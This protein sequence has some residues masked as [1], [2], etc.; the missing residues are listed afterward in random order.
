V[1]FSLFVMLVCLIVD[2]PFVKGDREDEDEYNSE[3][4]EDFN[5]D[6]SGEEGESLGSVDTDVEE[7]KVEDLHADF[8]DMPTSRAKK[9][10]TPNKKAAPKTASVDNLSTQMSSMKVTKVEYVSFTWRFPM[11]MYSVNEGTTKKIFIEIRKGVQ[12]PEE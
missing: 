3:E 1:R 9:S 7:N 4:D 12:L 8:E 11:A 5:G 2:S 10:T 6:K